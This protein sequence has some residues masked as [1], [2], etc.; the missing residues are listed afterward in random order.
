MPSCL[1]TSKGNQRKR[2]SELGKA[3]SATDSSSADISIH[4]MSKCKYLKEHNTFGLHSRQLTR[5]PQ[6]TI[7]HCQLRP[8]W[9]WEHR[10][11]IMDKWKSVAWSDGS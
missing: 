1:T 4:S 3:K 2:L 5:M 9:C 6:L 7:R 8:Q 10:D 11:W